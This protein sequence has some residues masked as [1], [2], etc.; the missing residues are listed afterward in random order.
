MNI[1][2]G[3]DIIGRKNTYEKIEIDNTF[4]A[5]ILKNQKLFKDWI[6]KWIWESIF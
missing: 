3:K 5:H 6:I 4:P 2:K 1:D